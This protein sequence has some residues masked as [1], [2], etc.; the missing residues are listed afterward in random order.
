MTPSTVHIIE[1]EPL[2]AALLDR[3]L[4]LAGFDSSLSSDGA[5]GWQEIQRRLPTLILLDL[6]LPGLSGQEICRM[7]RHN[8]ITRHIPIIMLT[9]IG[10]ETERIAGLDMGAD[11]Y[12]VKPFSPKEVVSRVRAVLRR[13]DAAAEGVAPMMNAAVSMQGPYFAVLLGKR[14]VILSRTETML[15]QTLLGREN[16]LLDAAELIPLPAGENPALLLK[17]L[18]RDI[19]GLR[20][21]LEN[22]G[23]GSLDMLPGFRYRFRLHA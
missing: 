16:A 5:S 9:A 7:V 13:Y 1:D 22:V 14:E 2:H 17:D 3:A 18:D 10:G 4:R 21:K 8:S 12:V 19:R 15:L 6:M 20:R 23:A 11:D